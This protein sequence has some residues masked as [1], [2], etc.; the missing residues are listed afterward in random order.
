MN[1]HEK[2]ATFREG[3]AGTELVFPK[4]PVGPEKRDLVVDLTGITRLDL[5]SLALL[6]TAQQQAE[7]EDRKVWLAG[8]PLRIWKSL[9]DMG[10][11][12]LFRFFPV[13]SHMAV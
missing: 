4:T 9:D 7:K 13:S 8:V 11:G 10:L 6:L 3:G 2:Q 1:E 12:R 5:K